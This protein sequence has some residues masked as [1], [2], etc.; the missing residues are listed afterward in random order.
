[1]DY[2]GYIVNRFALHIQSA[3]YFVMLQYHPQSLL[4]NEPNTFIK[5]QIQKMSVTTESMSSVLSIVFD[6]LLP[7]SPRCGGAPCPHTAP[8]D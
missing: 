7:P 6:L 5:K 8:G 4:D 1:M 2:V 3:Y